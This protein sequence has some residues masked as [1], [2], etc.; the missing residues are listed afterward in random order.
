MR[1]KI[2]ACEVFARELMFAAAVSPQIVDLTLMPF[3]LHDT[4]EELR[5]ELQKEVDATPYERYD[6]VALGY[7]LCS[8]GTVG[9]RAGKIPLVIPR[10]HDCITLLL[11]SR[12]RYSKEFS[13]HPGTYYYSPGWIERKTGEVQ[14]GIIDDAYEKRAQE[15]FE[16]Y[17]RKYGEDNARFLIQ[18]ESLWM[19][20]Y[21]RAAFIDTG[22]GNIEAYREFTKNLASERGWE[23]VEIRG[24]TCLLTRLASGDWNEKEFL[25]VRPGSSIQ[26]TYD[27]TIVREK[28]Q[29]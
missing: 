20:H 2:I 23:Y 9:I 7:G 21:T 13:Q 19:K 8:R 14:Q 28:I 12:A 24:D 27:G 29:E 5:K 18:Q 25:I 15:R 10:A 1:I 11:G 16:E 17:A 3:G 22:L 6:Y 4:P 26:E